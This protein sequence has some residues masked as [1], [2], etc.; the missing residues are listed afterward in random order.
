MAKYSRKKQRKTSPIAEILKSHRFTLEHAKLFKF[1]DDWIQ[2]YQDPGTGIESVPLRLENAFR[3]YASQSMKLTERR[4][5]FASIRTKDDQNS[6]RHAEADLLA[7]SGRNFTIVE[8][9]ASVSTNIL[10]SARAGLYTLSKFLDKKSDKISAGIAY[11]EMLPERTDYTFIDIDRFKINKAVKLWSNLKSREHGYAAVMMFKAKDI[12]AWAIKNGLESNWKDFN[13]A[14]NDHLQRRM[15]IDARVALKKT[16]KPQKS[17]SY[18]Q[19]PSENS[20]KLLEI[21]LGRLDK[22]ERP[23]SMLFKKAAA[24]RLSAKQFK[25]YVA[26]YG[27]DLRS[28]DRDMLLG[29]VSI[30][31]LEIIKALEE[32]QSP[33]KKFFDRDS[34][35]YE[36]L[37][38][39][40]LAE[41]NAE[42]FEFVEVVSAAYQLGFS[43]AEALEFM[44]TPDLIIALQSGVLSSKEDLELFQFTDEKTSLTQ[45]VAI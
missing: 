12:W 40:T 19:I 6:F 14:E 17:S 3:E 41:G 29:L 20:L 8:V 5:F 26:E 34:G 43:Y 11:L 2:R 24:N 13:A 21:A 9:K 35:R 44:K 37:R 22:T 10:N 27:L 25:T 33:I 16:S 4:Y 42:T 18:D 36:I 1:K 39:I 32:C 38:Q 23:G 15:R 30:R 28:Q 31:K 45:A 7:K